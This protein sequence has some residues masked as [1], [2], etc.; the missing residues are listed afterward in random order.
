M[1]GDVDDIVGPPHNPK[2]TIGIDVPG[3]R[4][5]IVPGVEGEIGLFKVGVVPPE[6]GKTAWRQWP[7]DG[8]VAVPA[9][10]NLF[11]FLV[12]DVDIITGNGFRA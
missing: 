10:L 11:S 7:S 3:I 2:I 1:S 9:G 5:E 6:C 4:G 8:K 12:E